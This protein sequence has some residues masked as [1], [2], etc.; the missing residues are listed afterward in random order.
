M[1]ALSG[2][3]LFNCFS[4]AELIRL[5]HSDN[6][7]ITQ[8][9]KGQVIHLQNEI[10][11]TMDIVLKGRV[12]V[13]KINEEGNILKINVFSAGS[14]LGA[15][16]LFSNRNFYPM[17]VIS[18]SQTVLLHIYKELVLELSQTNAHFMT[19]LMTVISDRILLLTDKIDAISLKTVRQ[20]IVDFLK[21]EYSIQKSNVL[22][23]TISKRDLAERFGI[24]RTS[25]SRE[26]NKMRKEGLLE[27]SAKTITL[28]RI[29]IVK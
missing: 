6:Y 16:L 29:D 5:F 17:T 3:D 26:L 7:R 21:Y 25:L 28:K 12:A 23:L 24:Q 27:Y 13:Q 18:E 10:C 11:R 14:I 15:N 4:Q 8:Y 1:Y 20:K 2:F 22:K 9:N 19:G